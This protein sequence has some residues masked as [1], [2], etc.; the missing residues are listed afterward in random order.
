MASSA[1][2]FMDRALIVRIATQSRAGMPLVT[3]LW[4]LRDGSK[5][6][7]GTRRGSP[8][9]RNAF[10]NPSVVMTFGDRHGRP[11]GGCCGRSARPEWRTTKK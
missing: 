8:H 9:E 7:I 5:I 11:T 4:F 6:I 1:D 10:A 3:P 2:R